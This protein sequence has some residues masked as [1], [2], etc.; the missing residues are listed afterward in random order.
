M[1]GFL[2]ASIYCI[3]TLIRVRLDPSAGPPTSDGEL[4]EYCYI[5]PGTCTVKVPDELRPIYSCGRRETGKLQPFEN[6][7]ILGDGALGIYA[8]A[9]AS[10]YEYRRFVVRDKI[11]HRL[12]FVRDFGA[13]ETFNSGEMTTEEIVQKATDITGGFGMDVVM[14]VAGV[15]N[16][17]P[18][19]LKCLRKGG[20]LVEIGNSFPGPVYDCLLGNP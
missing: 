15:P 4:A 19:G 6:V 1:P 14:E 16:L 7:I 13:T 18:T 17:I 10:H 3:Y 5:T 2:L 12:E 20:R 11:N 8:A 9:L